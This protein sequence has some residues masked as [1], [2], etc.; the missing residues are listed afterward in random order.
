[1]KL[2]KATGFGLGFLTIVIQALSVELKSNTIDTHISSGQWLIEHFS[3]YCPHCINFAPT[4]K[5]LANDFDHLAK[6]SNFHFGT[7]DCT[8][9][10]DLCSEHSITGYPE[11]QLWDNGQKV[12]KYIEARDYDRLAEYIKK[13]AG[14]YSE[15]EFNEQSFDD[16][17]S[18][19]GSEEEE[20]TPE[21][22]EE[23]T[24]EEEEAPEEEDEVPEEDEQEEQEEETE[25]EAPE[26]EEAVEEEIQKKE[27]IVEKKV[28]NLLP[29]P[30][31]I[32]V[33]LDSKQLKQVTCKFL[34]SGSLNSMHH[35]VLIA[36]H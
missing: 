31:G 20:T 1:M 18:D 26:E 25:E 28:E 35:G 22:E 16:Q 9:Q 3:P 6:E 17:V 4:W 12:E 23:V 7:I 5:Q 14:A 15:T 19:D 11:I 27:E 33:D 30:S 34:M 2:F 36:K 24:E 29:N 8:V 32:S 13:K 10:G 21:D